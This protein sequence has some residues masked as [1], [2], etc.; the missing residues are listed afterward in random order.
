M[1]ILPSKIRVSPVKIEKKQK[2]LI[3]GL[4]HFVS[5]ILGIM[6]PTD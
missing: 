4:E 3:G 1:V 5:N 6:I 2:H